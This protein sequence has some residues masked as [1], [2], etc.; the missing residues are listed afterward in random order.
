MPAT[1]PGGSGDDEEAS[2]STSTC[3]TSQLCQWKAPKKRKESTL[4]VSDATFEKHDYTKPNKR[5]IKRMEDFDPR[6]QEFRGTVSSRLPELLRALQGEQLCFSLL[7]DP[8][9]QHETI[10]QPTDHNVPGLEKLKRTMSAFKTS[11]Q[12]TPE[13]ARD[14][15][16][17][18]REQSLSPLWYA[19]RKHRI[20]AS[21]FGSVLSRKTDTPPDC[22]VLRVIQPKNFS[23]P[24]TR[25]GRECEELAVKEYVSYQRSHGHSDIMVTASGVIINPDYFFLG[26]SPDGAVYDPSNPE[27]PYGFLEVK[28]PYTVRNQSPSEACATS[29]FFCTLEA[30]G[31]LKLR[32]SHQYYAQIQGQMAIGERPW[33]DFVVYTSK[34]ASVQRVAFNSNFWSDKL[35]PKLISFYDSCILPE[36]VS[37]VHSLGLPIRDMSKI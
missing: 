10:H 22:L 14:I 37:P 9:F 23:T 5:K 30:S 13:E 16:R 33:C 3:V 26:A 7:L 20:T 17:N 27:Q 29:G 8:Q 28:C 35:L 21:L 11:L 36:L 6:P 31:E 15:E 4:P 2:G 25:Y 1:V 32:E 12:I 34:G 19:V 24:A 18:T